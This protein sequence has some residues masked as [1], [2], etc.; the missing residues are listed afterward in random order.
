MTSIRDFVVRPAAGP[1]VARGFEDMYSGAVRDVLHGTGQET[2]EAVDFLKKAD[3][4]RYKPAAGVEYPKGHLG[5]SLQQ[6]AQLVKSD[7]GLEVAFTDVGGWDHHA[8]EGGVSGQLAQRLRELGTAVAAF[9]RD[10]GPQMDRVVLL[11]LTEFGRTARENGNRGTDHGHASV[12]FALGGGVRG[13]KV[14]GRFPGL[15]PESLY[16]GRDLALTT[17]FRDLL[18]EVLV[19]H[20]GARDLGAVFPGHPVSAGHYPG[21]IRA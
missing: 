10:L 3:P 20:L 4:E 6:I 19:R 18:G 2:F 5:D 9:G 14:L 21:V 15:A 12:S 17:D 11:T 13:G 7:V 8:G 1:E 16:E